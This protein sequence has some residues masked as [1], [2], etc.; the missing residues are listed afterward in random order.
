MSRV[1]ALFVC[2]SVS[3]IAPQGKKYNR[4]RPSAKGVT[5]TFV[6]QWGEK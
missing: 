4:T 1:Q 2:V 5:K 3:A 6:G